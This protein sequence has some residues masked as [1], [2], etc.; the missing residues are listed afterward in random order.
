MRCNTMGDQGRT[1]GATKKKSPG[2]KATGSI[3]ARLATGNVQGGG[4]DKGVQLGVKG[5]GL[6]K[7]K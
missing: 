1:S 4:A 6:K 5:S 2:D 7:R 3:A